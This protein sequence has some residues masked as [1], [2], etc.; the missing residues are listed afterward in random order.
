[1]KFHLRVPF[2]ILD[3]NRQNEE[4][5]SAEV[6]VEAASKE[7]AIK[8]FLVSVQVALQRSTLQPV[9]LAASPPT[10]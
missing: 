8:L 4:S 5:F 10:S 1:M 9:D 2:L 3:E 7:E 6:A